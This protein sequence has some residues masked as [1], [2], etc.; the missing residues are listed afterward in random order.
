MSLLTDLKTG[1]AAHLAADAVGAWRPDGSAYLPGETAIVTGRLRDDPDKQIALATYHIPNGNSGADV[2][3]AIQARIRGEA[4]DERSADDL[5]EAV[6]DSLNGLPYVVWGDTAISQVYLQSGVE[7]GPDA[8]NR[9]EH[10]LNFY[11]QI[12][13]HTAHFPE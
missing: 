7:L 9:T 2:V 1:A 8:S 5:A 6:T 11:V 10:T 13:R 4:N 3:Y 12:T